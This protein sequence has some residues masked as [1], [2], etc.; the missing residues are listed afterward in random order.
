MA[1]QE[2]RQGVCSGKEERHADLAKEE[3]GER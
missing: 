2:K 1:E 3:V